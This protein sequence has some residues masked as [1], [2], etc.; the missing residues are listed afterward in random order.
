MNYEVRPPSRGLVSTACV[1]DHPEIVRIE[2]VVFTNADCALTWK[3]FSDCCSWPKFAD[4]YKS[5]SWS[6]NP[7][8][9]GSRLRIEFCAPLNLAIDG[10]ITVCVPPHQVAWLS[11]ARGYAMEQWFSLAPYPGCGTRVSTWAELTGTHVER[12][13]IGK[14]VK[15]VIAEWLENLALECDRAASRHAS[16]IQAVADQ[17]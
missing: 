7:W 6:G 1:E 8:M 4:I 11:H 17:A 13:T 16:D 14:Q 2:Y 15:A 5:V 3:V 9:P 10:V 12:D